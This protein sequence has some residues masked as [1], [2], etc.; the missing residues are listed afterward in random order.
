MRLW[1]SA[2]ALIPSVGCG[3]LLGAS[4]DDTPRRDGGAGDGSAAD[5]QIQDAVVPDGGSAD[6]ATPPPDGST[7]CVPA[8]TEVCN[9]VDDDCDGFVD[10][11]ARCVCPID[12]IAIAETIPD[13]RAPRIAWSG[14]DSAVVYQEGA[15]VYFRVV[16]DVGSPRFGGFVGGSAVSAYDVAWGPGH[17][18]VAAIESNAVRLTPIAIDG[19]VGLPI[20]VPLPYSS[21]EVAIAW[22]SDAWTIVS[23]DRGTGAM[24]AAR[25]VADGS[26]LIGTPAIAAP[27]TLAPYAPRLATNGGDAGL[28]FVGLSSGGGEGAFFVHLDAGIGPSRAIEVLPPVSSSLQTNPP[29]IAWAGASFMV[30]VEVE[31]VI[32]WADLTASSVDGTGLPV[33]ETLGADLG[34]PTIAIGLGPFIAYD[35]RGDGA[36]RIAALRPERALGFLSTGTL[37]EIEPS[38][39]WTGANYWIAYA[40]DTVGGSS[41][42]WMRCVPP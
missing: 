22:A 4:D 15:D 21:S 29:A 35:A 27:R 33:T 11:A 5:A 7:T 1:L 14:R 28:V 19:T 31:D 6:G 16:D 2:L 42:I 24:M 40:R 3:L 17:W 10:D 23:D 12:P 20:R 9:G 13:S 37:D 18:A 26:A 30:A 8:G 36:R 39:V 34:A 38:A 32:H 25:V 41:D